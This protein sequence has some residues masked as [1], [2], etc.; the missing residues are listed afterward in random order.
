MEAVWPATW[1]KGKS[2]F[3]GAEPLKPHDMTW[4]PGLWTTIVAVSHQQELAHLI[5]KTAQYQL[6]DNNLS[7]RLG[8]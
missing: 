2:S 5:E 1:K 4:L 7:G 8:Q 6:S 3:S